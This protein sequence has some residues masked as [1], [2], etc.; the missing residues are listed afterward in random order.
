M[1][2]EISYNAQQETLILTF[3]VLVD[4]SASSRELTMLLN[5]LGKG[6]LLR[7]NEWHHLIQFI[8]PPQDNEYSLSPTQTDS[9]LTVIKKDS[10][11]TRKDL[12]LM[13]D[14][15]QQYNKIDL[16]QAIRQQL[17]EQGIR[18]S[19]YSSQPYKI[20]LHNPSQRYLIIRQTNIQTK[21]LFAAIKHYETTSFKLSY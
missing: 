2:E 17:N 7:P 14:Y 15:L 13:A 8:Y 18:L 20:A 10:K 12:Y 1:Q 19:A 9:L 3:H 6:H 5:A 4:Y 16:H 21:S 11:T